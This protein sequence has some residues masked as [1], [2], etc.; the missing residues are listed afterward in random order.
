MNR[1]SRLGAADLVCTAIAL[2]L[3][4]VVE[5]GLRT[6]RLP[7]MSRILGIP[8][9]IDPPSRRPDAIP[10]TIPG[11]ARRRL[12]AARRALRHW[13]FGD[14]CLRKALVGGAMIRS[15]DPV[16][17]I[18]VA[19][20]EGALKAHAWIELEGLSLDPGSRDFAIVEGVVTR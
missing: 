7:R 1:R 14:T 5:I 6:L 16:L 9:G 19:R 17:R 15:L 2:I 12:A 4:A 20:H 10:V 3:A 18:G 13:P 8:L 11:W